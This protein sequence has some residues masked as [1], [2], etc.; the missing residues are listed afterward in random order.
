[1]TEAE[2]LDKGD[3]ILSL[4]AERG[5]PSPRKQRLFAVACCR[6]IQHLPGVDPRWLDSLAVAER[7]AD[8]RSKRADLNLSLSNVR[9]SGTARNR[10]CKI[11]FVEMASN[12]IWF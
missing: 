3:P 6:R 4:E 2:W 11:L 9:A 12:A 7:Y 10:T 5:W 8:R 1:M